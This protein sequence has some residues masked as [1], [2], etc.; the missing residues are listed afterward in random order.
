MTVVATVIVLLVVLLSRH[1]DG[2]WLVVAGTVGRVEV[3]PDHVTEGF[4][5]GGRVTWRA[6]YPVTYIINGREYKSRVDSG[7][8]RESKDE[9]ERALPKTIPTCHVRYKPESPEVSIAD[10]H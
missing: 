3:V 1:D 4:G 5:R 9:V 7:I 6:E 8:R 2:D 10:C